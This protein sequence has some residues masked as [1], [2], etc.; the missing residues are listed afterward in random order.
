LLH[1]AG[2]HAGIA[3]G[4]WLRVQLCRANEFGLHHCSSGRSDFA[5]CAVRGIW[6]EILFEL[7]T[8]GMLQTSRYK[9]SIQDSGALIWGAEGSRGRKRRGQGTRCEGYCGAMLSA[10]LTA[11]CS[12]LVPAIH[13][14]SRRRGMCVRDV[15]DG[16]FV[17]DDEA[18]GIVRS[19]C[20]GAVRVQSV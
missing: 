5:D 13:M 11:P 6:F 14:R 18:T 16:A 20:W 9:C 17:C 8:R 3:R 2:S 15:R 1:S 12:R 7:I 10:P 19:L 4:F